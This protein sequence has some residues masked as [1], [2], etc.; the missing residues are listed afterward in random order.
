MLNRA[1]HRPY[2][3]TLIELMVVVAIIAILAAMAYPAY[4]RYAFRARRVDGK[5]LLAEIATAEERYNSINN[6]YTNNI[7]GAAPG[8]L[9]LTNI[10]EKAY[11]TVA[12][13]LGAGGLTYVLTA[14]PQ[15]IQVPDA[16]GPL[17]LD[18]TKA[19]TP[20]KGVMPANSNGDCW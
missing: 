7:T 20:V 15:G 2:G 10:S 4:S 8:G 18:S 14:T 19:K 13:A 3:F 11:Y 1:T 6:V 12:A 5:N 16:C 9:G 17:T